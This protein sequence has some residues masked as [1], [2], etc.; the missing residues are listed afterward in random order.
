M[1]VNYRNQISPTLLLQSLRIPK[2]ISLSLFSL[3]SFQEQRRM[4]ETVRNLFRNSYATFAV[5]AQYKRRIFSN[6]LLE[7]SN[8]ETVSLQFVVCVGFFALF[9]EHYLGVHG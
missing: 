4:V 2:R 9:T 7:I 1:S 5:S 3:G 8:V 6:I